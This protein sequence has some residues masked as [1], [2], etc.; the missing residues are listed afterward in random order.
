M[1]HEA[2]SKHEAGGN[3]G[4]FRLGGTGGGGGVVAAFRQGQTQ[5]LWRRKDVS[6][7]VFTAADRKTQGRNARAT[8]DVAGWL[9]G[10]TIKKGAGGGSFP[11]RLTVWLTPLTTKKEGC[12]PGCESDSS[13]FQPAAAGKVNGMVNTIAPKKSRLPAVG[14]IPATLRRCWE[15]DKTRFRQTEGENKASTNT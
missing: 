9:Q 1:T 2:R 13:P 8:G 10:A 5:A 3:S 11:A 4:L 15:T 6:L 12:P 7:L 14:T